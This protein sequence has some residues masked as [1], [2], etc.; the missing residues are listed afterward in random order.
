MAFTDDLWRQ[1]AQLGPEQS[2]IGYTMPVW[3][4]LASALLYRE[5]ITMTALVGIALAM[6]AAVVGLG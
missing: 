2:I 3:A 6:S 4:L 1:H 5:K